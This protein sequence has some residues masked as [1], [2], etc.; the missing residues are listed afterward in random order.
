MMDF[1]EP[2]EYEQVLA[3]RL[4]AAIEAAQQPFTPEN[5]ER[6]VSAVLGIYFAIPSWARRKVDERVGQPV[7]AALARDLLLTEN[8]AVP[9]EPARLYQNALRSL[10][11]IVD[12]LEESGLILQRARIEYGEL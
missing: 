10:G 5:V 4:N 7:P 1:K 9:E 12:V 8:K 6:L 3:W 11:T 2:V